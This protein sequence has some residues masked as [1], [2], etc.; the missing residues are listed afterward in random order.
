M[1]QGTTGCTPNSVLKLFIPFFRYSWRLS[2]INTHYIGISHRGAH[3]GIGVHSTIPWGIST[4]Q[5]HRMSGTINGETVQVA[6][7]TLLS[8]QPSR[9]FRGTGRVEVW[10][11]SFF[12]LKIV[13]FKRPKRKPDHLPT[14]PFFRL[15]VKLRAC[16]VRG[17][18]LFFL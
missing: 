11:V 2:P 17:M 7:H 18:Q 12:P 15:Y 6:A 9:D 14:F 13:C 16:M 3:V 1:Y 10:L 8:R 4:Q 5:V